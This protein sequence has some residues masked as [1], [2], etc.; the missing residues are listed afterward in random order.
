LNDGL[1][2]V[3]WFCPFTSHAIGKE[4]LLDADISAGSMIRSKAVKQASVPHPVTVTVARLLG[5]YSPDTSGNAIHF[6]DFRR[7][8][9]DCRR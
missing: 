8:F 5:E 4:N 2:N 3:L 9:E 1:A 7:V 6:R